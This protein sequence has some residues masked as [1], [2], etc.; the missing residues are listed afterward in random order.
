MSSLI[1]NCPAVQG[2]H[3]TQKSLIRERAS[4]AKLKRTGKR[5]KVRM[6][7]FLAGKKKKKVE[8]E[9]HLYTIFYRKVFISWEPGQSSPLVTV[10]GRCQYIQFTEKEVSW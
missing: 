3:S 1:N 9:W 2:K 5:D 8:E 4:D 7:L 10:N 6:L